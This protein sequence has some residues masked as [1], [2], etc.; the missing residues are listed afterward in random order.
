M[1][2]SPREQVALN[3]ADTCVCAD[4]NQSYGVAVTKATDQKGK[5]YWS[6][7]FAKARTLDGIIRVYS[8]RFIQVKWQGANRGSEVFR[9][10][11]EA[12]RFLMGFAG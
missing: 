7:T 5:S 9:T 4:L 3:L 10:E 8:E 11:Y 2:V 1:S 6:V 12:K